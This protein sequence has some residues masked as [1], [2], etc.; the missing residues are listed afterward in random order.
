MELKSGHVRLPWRASHK[1]IFLRGMTK[2][3]AH[4]LPLVIL[5]LNF[6]R[7]KL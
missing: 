3:D 1:L 6:I 4:D 2:M 7:N 5:T